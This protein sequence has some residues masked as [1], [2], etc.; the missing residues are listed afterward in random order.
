MTTIA[1]RDGIIAADTQE[2]VGGFRLI[3]SPKILHLPN[4]NVLA[5][6][7]ESAKIE[8]AIR[9]FS[10]DWN[11]NLDKAPDF[12]KSFEAILVSKGRVY[13]CTASCIPVPLGNP[14]YAIGHGWQL[15]M[16]AMQ[17]GMSA[18]DA[19][20]FASELDVFTNGEVQ[21]V[22]VKHLLQKEGPKGP[23]R[24]IKRKAVP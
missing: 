1:I 17:L 11:T 8:Q 16:A 9:F 4:G 3:S 20:K 22:D 10:D 21:L 13:F 14:I 24:S 5:A 18:E 15:A 12:K 23:G 19:V 2:T 7:G 6:A